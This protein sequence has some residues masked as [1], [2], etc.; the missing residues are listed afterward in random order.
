MLAAAVSAERLFDVFLELLRPLGEVVDVVLES[1][2]DRADHS[3]EDLHREGID[4]P[5]LQSQLCDFEHSL[6]NDGFAG[7]AVVS[8]SAPMEVQFDEH[9]L[10]IVYAED[11][12]PFEAILR[13]AG[14]P[15]IDDLK[16]I[17]E[18]E[19]VHSTSPEHRDAFESL[20]YRLGVGQM[21][22]RV[23]W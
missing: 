7:L 2:H 19:H 16:L 3:H 21:V 18:G 22:E 11:L 6:L 4:L 20:C 13:Q 1:S 23:N 10:L 5:V 15:R 9:K 14:L 12:E 8:T 17:T